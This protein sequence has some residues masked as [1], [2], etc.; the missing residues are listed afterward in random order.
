[1]SQ[2][3]NLIEAQER[4]A[5]AIRSAEGC[6]LV[7]YL[8]PLKYP[9]VGWGHKVTAA[10]KLFLGDRI[11]RNRA[12]QLFQSDMAI[13]TRTVGSQYRERLAGMS[14]PRVAV[15]IEMAFVLGPTG[16]E[17]FTKMSQAISEECWTLAGDEI[18]AS[19]WWRDAE[20]LPGIRTRILRLQK[21]MS[22]GDWHDS[23]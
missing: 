4:A 15:L 20:D 22:T 14:A 5:I 12:E 8:C 19:D 11:T 16:F 21:Q 7:V 13:A 3:S 1:M 2:P 9:T 10:D 18:K 6:G 23:R 17:G